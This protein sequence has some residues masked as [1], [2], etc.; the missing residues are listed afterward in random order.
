MF[1]YT[2]IERIAAYRLFKFYR[3]KGYN[4]KQ[5]VVIADAFSDIFLEELLRNK[6][7]GFNVKYVLTNSQLIRTKF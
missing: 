3:A 6:E 4:T 2:V 5:V 1:F 7:W